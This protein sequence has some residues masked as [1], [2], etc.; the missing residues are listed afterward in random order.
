M[1]RCA[2][3][4]NPP[5]T[6]T[7]IPPSTPPMPPLLP[8]FPTYHQDRDLYVCPYGDNM[9]WEVGCF[10]FSTGG[11]T[12]LTYY[13]HHR[14]EHVYKRHPSRWMRLEF[15]VMVGHFHFAFCLCT[16]A[17]CMCMCAPIQAGAFPAS[18]LP[19]LQ[20]IYIC[21]QLLDMHFYFCLCTRWILHFLFLFFMHF[22][23][24]SFC[25]VWFCSDILEEKE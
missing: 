16:A 12:S 23:L 5:L 15:V 1:P 24:M 22:C 25:F 19:S 4:P 3:T 14:E 11:E 10:P 20:N 18:L 9:F 6:P 21:S 8:P 2:E 13:T 17:A 7:T